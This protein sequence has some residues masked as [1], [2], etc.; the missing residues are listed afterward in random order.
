MIAAAASHKYVSLNHMLLLI[1]VFVLFLRKKF[2]SDDTF[3]AKE[4]ILGQIAYHH[5]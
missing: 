3:E 2:T 5:M 1:S 4:C